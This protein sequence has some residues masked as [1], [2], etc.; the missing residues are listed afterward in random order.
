[1]KRLLESRPDAFMAPVSDSEPGPEDEPSG[2]GPATAAEVYARI[3][4]ARFVT[5]RRPSGHPRS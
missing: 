4:C 1:M 3:R 5:L 2:K